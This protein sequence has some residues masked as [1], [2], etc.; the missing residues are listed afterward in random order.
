[1]PPKK[2]ILGTRIAEVFELPGDVV[3]NLPR[4]TLIGNAQMAVENH[5]GLVRYD[6]ASITVGCGGYQMIVDGESLVIGNVSNEELIIRG[7]I[8]RIVFEV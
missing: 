5:R 6:P 3:L 2:S 8:L 4:V 1:M 7:T